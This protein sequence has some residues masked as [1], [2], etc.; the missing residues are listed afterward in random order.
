MSTDG[1]DN[2][3]YNA[4]GGAGGISY[5]DL[6]PPSTTTSSDTES[7]QMQQKGSDS[8]SETK[9]PY[10]S[11]SQT[12]AE[13]YRPS[14]DI[15]TVQADP[16]SYPYP[17]LTLVDLTHDSSNI[18]AGAGKDSSGDAISR[19]GTDAVRPTETA[20]DFNNIETGEAVD[21]VAS[22]C[23]KDSAIPGQ[24]DLTLERLKSL[25]ST[26]RVS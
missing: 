25:E 12:I 7:S 4:G 10:E 8:L 1:S 9:S 26:A 13:A 16:A 6:N 20:D 22:L 23:P 21:R 3:Y 11:L 2:G 17:D 24:L 14:A 15:T 5:A 19:S 18:V